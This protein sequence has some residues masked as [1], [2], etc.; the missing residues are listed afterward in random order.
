MSN[1]TFTLTEGLTMFVILSGFLPSMDSLVVKM[2]S[3]GTESLPTLISTVTFLTNV[4]Y[5]MLEKDFTLNESLL[6]S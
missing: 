4:K 5:L 2:V 6:Y 1:M 3:V